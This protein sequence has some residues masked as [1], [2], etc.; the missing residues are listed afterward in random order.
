MPG[1]V[2]GAQ[3]EECTLCGMSLLYNTVVHL[4][5]VEKDR[6]SQES[7]LPFAGYAR[8]CDVRWTKRSDYLRPLDMMWL[9]RRRFAGFLHGTAQ[10]LSGLSPPHTHTHTHLHPYP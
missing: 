5:R 7:F 10:R 4:Y 2:A 3:I 9:A 6:N 1:V 8:L